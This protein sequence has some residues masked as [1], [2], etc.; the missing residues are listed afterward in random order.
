MDLIAPP[1]KVYTNKYISSMSHVMCVLDI[2]SRKYITS[3]F[4]DNNLVLTQP[5]EMSTLK[6]SIRKLIY[7]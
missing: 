7:N 4:K 6:Y 1:K 5:V 3:E 2:V